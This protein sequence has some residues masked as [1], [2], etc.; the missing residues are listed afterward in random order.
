LILTL[1]L[2]IER[3]VDHKLVGEASSTR[4]S[5]A[6]RTSGGTN[7]TACALNRCSPDIAALVSSVSSSWMLTPSSASAREMSR[8]MPGG[9]GRR[10]RAAARGRLPRPCAAAL[11]HDD[12]QVARF[13]LLQ[14]RDQRCRLLRGHA[15]WTMPGELPARSPSGFFPARAVLRCRTPRSG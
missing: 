6:V 2:F 7:S 5:S 12:A 13:E 8:T 11:D 10:G 15:K 9:P 14:R 4:R 1:L 3:D